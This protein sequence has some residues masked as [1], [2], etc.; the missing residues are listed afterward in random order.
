MRKNYV[1]D[2]NI[3][4][5]NPNCLNKFEENNV[6]IPQIVIE[7]LDS[8]K[9]APG[10]LGFSA[11]EAIRQISE[12]RK[13]GKL[14]DGVE[15]QDGGKL[16]VLENEKI[17]DLDMSKNDN[18][19]LA[20]AIVLRNAMEYHHDDTN[21]EDHDCTKQP[22]EIKS[23]DDLDMAEND[24]KVLACALTLKD[25]IDQD[26]HDNFDDKDCTE[27]PKVILVTND[28][29]LQIK[30]DILNLPVEEYR[31]DRPI[32]ENLY[33]GRSTRHTDGKYMDMFAKEGELSPQCFHEEGLDDL[34]TN[35]FV[36]IKSWEGGSLLGKYDGYNVV[37]LNFENSHPCDLSTRN[38]GQ[39]FLQEAL[40]SPADIHPL[41]ICS[42]PAGTG[43]TLF[44]IACGLEQ[45]M[46]MRNYKRVLVC[47]PNVTMDEE[48]G[49][50]PGTE[51]E[52]ISPLLRGVYDNLEVL[53]GDKD[54]SHEQMLDKIKE[55]FQRGY[56][57]AQ[58]LAYLRGRSITDTYIIIDEAQNASP[59]QILSIVTR[60]GEGSKIV[61][62]G[63][64]NQ[65]DNP[66]LDK[67]NNGLVYATERMKGS[68]LCEVVS[69][70]ESECTRSKLAKEA[71]DRLKR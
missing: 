26:Y 45:V 37:K 67:R 39:I 59:T 11:R 38:V 10:E 2:T 43:K 57:T 34:I 22:K 25:K 68:S 48:I 9:K 24:I 13:K 41:T 66:R 32:S 8:K 14:L 28:V 46:N 60:A 23:I 4:L 53:F 16:Y 29:N 51:Q 36:N 64:P 52:K 54:D 69:F 65:I 21:G 19:I 44:A 71:S 42:G 15:T 55:L 18:K 6:F 56:I 3:L 17:D 70:D 33:G 40:M 58:S 7:E 12:Y 31:N 63:D 50:L 61:L 27:A 5:H 49:F 62:L 1:L 47:R 35:E 20:C 30:A